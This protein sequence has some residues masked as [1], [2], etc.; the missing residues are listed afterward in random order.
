MEQYSVFVVFDINFVVDYVLPG[1]KD[2]IMKGK[3]QT[4]GA[5]VQV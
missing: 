2:G 5:W 3:R 4:E 1:G